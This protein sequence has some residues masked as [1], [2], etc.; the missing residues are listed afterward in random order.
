[1]NCG[2]FAVEQICSYENEMSEDED[3]I[4]D[5]PV[6]RHLAE[7]LKIV[8]NARLDVKIAKKIGIKT[9][10][11]FIQGIAFFLFLSNAF[12]FNLLH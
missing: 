10:M 12:L 11:M 8:K 7:S 5:I 2:K 9:F 4:V 1:M 6:F 3:T